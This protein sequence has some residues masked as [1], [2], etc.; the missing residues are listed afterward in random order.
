[1]RERGRES[2][3]QAEVGAGSRRASGDASSMV[4]KQYEIAG[5]RRVRQVVGSQHYD[6]K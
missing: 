2:V 3:L 4:F 1:M 6:R 5:C